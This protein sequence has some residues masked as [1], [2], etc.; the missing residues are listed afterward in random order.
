MLSS[1][2]FIFDFDSTFIQVE[3]VDVLAEICLKNDPKGDEK[4]AYFR[5]L[6]QKCMNG[7][8]SY[9]ETVR[10]RFELLTIT[11]R[12]IDQTIAI[13]QEKI[14][15]SFLRNRE[16]FKQYADQI[17]VLSGA[18]IEI[19]WPVVA[20]FGLK[21]DHVFGN[22]FLY[23]FEGNVRDYDRH[24]P[25]S[26]DQSKVKLMHQLKLPGDLIMVGDGYNDYEL[27]ENGMVSLFI[28]FTENVYREAVVKVA[29][30]VIDSIEGLFL[31]C[32]IPFAAPQTNT[33]V[34]L[35]ENI[36]P[37]VSQ[38]FRSL[39]Y[40]VDTLPEALSG[41]AL[42][43]KLQGVQI[44]GIRSKTQLTAE[45]IASAK[46]LAVVGAFCIGTNQIDLTACS[47][48]G[49][50]V[51]NAPYSNTRSVVELTLAGMILL[52]RKALVAFEQ[53]KKGIW[54]KTSEGAHEI[55]GRTLGIIG[56][57]HIG[58]QL[59]VI[60]E[61]LGLRVLFYDIAD[62]LPLGNAKAC[63]SMNE[64][65]SQSDIV[66]LHVDGRAENASL[67]DQ[68][69]LS[70]MKPGAI[71]LNLSRDF[72]VDNDALVK[73]L[74]NK[75]IAG[76][77][78]D[79][80]P[81]EPL[82]SKSEFK[83]PYAAFDNVFL[84]PHIGGSTEEAQSHIGDYVSHHIS[85]YVEEGHTIGSVNFPALMLPST[86]FTERILH[87]HENVP[88]ILAQINAYFAKAGINILGQLLKTNDGLGYVITDLNKTLSEED[89]AGLSQIPHTIKVRSIQ[90][91]A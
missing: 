55:R 42:T 54:H 32:G 38:H 39:G 14:T 43:D 23:D 5:E 44:L 34:V 33:K 20:P 62:K 76:V 8:L 73:A 24:S 56:Y 79:V 64:L 3:A 57:G 65:L 6:T 60:A 59:S 53:M 69:A 36:H 71:L 28:A 15:P 10:E 61:A 84:T 48:A 63:T 37:A 85:D 9:Q 74:Q 30:S 88:G 70:L 78:L 75:H 66:S 31:T 67:I 77:A 82:A 41:K 46:Q 22:R 27:K 83:T 40:T 25:L 86:P 21:R 72:V 7:Q 47:K 45:V 2:R 49:I 90:R 58:S 12:E 19:L 91:T 50:A 4:L 13:I 29:D 11:Q 68:K 81:H 18:F 26:Q 1:Q 89:L 16:F 35:L 80:F 17:Y 87:V 51:F 52:T